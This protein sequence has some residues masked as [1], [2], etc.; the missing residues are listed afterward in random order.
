MKERGSEDVMRMAWSIKAQCLRRM[1]QGT[2]SAVSLTRVA[3]FAEGTASG[4]RWQSQF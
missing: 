3:G 2:R 4:K 1:V